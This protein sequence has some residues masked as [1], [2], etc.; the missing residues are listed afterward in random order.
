MITPETNGA[1]NPE[2]QTETDLME[3]NKTW[4]KNH[5]AITEAMI[6]LIRENERWPTK[7]EIAEQTGL[8]RWT[9]YKHLEEFEQQEVSAGEVV[10]LKLM[11]SQILAK[12]VEMAVAGEVKAM[13]LSFEVMGIL[14]KGKVQVNPEAHKQDAEANV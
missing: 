12:M 4:D 8:T 6:W 2:E 5:V 9:V 13:R 3:K 14:K 10:E 11:S 1:Q 7:A